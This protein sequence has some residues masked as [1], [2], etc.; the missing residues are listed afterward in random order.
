[1]KKAEDYLQQWLQ[2][3]SVL[4]EIVALI[5]NEQI[6]F[7]PWENAMTMG[8]LITHIVFS[9]DMFVKTVKNGTFTPPNKR[10]QYQTIDEVRNIVHELTEKTIEDLQSI[11]ENQLET[12][13]EINN[14]VGTGSFWLSAAKDHEIHH[15]GQLFTYA[16][17]VGVENLPFL[18]KR[19]L[20]SK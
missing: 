14:Y 2:H 6:N 11:N 1:M 8:A 10:K 19:P 9:T 12:Q 3:R 13:I 17:I 18:I 7:K 5:S 16:R 15:K 4:Q 20:K